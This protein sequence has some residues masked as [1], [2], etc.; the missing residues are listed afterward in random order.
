MNGLATPDDRTL[1][2]TKQAFCKAP[3]C[4]TATTLLIAATSAWH[5]HQIG[6]HGLAAMIR[7]ILDWL[8]EPLPSV[9]TDHTDHI[10]DS[11]RRIASYTDGKAR[12]N[13]Y[14]AAMIELTQ[15][16]R[17]QRSRPTGD[18]DT[19]MLSGRIAKIH[20]HPGTY[21][22]TLTV[23]QPY[24]H[25]VLIAVTGDTDYFDHDELSTDLRD[26][27]ELRHGEGPAGT[28]FTFRCTLANGLLV[29]TPSGIVRIDTIDGA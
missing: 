19:V 6:D 15:A 1:A 5:D 26:V 8:A 14:R 9:A 21:F 13:V 28:P 16:A 2:R 23:A 24:P 7:L 25:E 4:D 12:I 27:L 3:S 22:V 17:D 29:S 20:S 18:G 11:A 10:A